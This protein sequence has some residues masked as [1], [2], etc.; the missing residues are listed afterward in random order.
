[1]SFLS[2]ILKSVINP[3]TL[4][5]L[6]MGPAG[7]ASLA[8]RTIGT[9]IMQQVIQQVGQKLGLPQSI[10]DIAQTAFSA[11]SG[12]QGMPNT[13]AGA[14]GQLAQQ[15][16]LSPKQQGELQRQ[17]NTALEQF[18]KDALEGKNNGEDA[19]SN[20]RGGK[21]E[22]FLVA[23]AKALG[24]AMDSKM[25]RMMDVSRTIDKETQAAN[26]SGGKRQ[27]VVGELSAELQGLGQEVG[28]LAQAVA[29]SV[30]S[31]GE[32]ASTLARKG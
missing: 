27:A 13:I 17:A 15:F 25:N 10:I 16:D 24:K 23:F 12:T 4:M 2:G 30:K 21:A 31:I 18:T 8:L 14:I 20:L 11:A 9:A 22:S 19:P 28:M 6:A 7:W 29:N 3:A 26:S 1:M 5:Q 32:A